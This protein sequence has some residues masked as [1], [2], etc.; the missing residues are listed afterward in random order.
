MNVYQCRGLLG[1]AFCITAVLDGTVAADEAARLRVL[2]YNIHHGA[3]VDGKLDLERIAA[4]IRSASPDVVALQEVDQGTMRTNG[5]KQAEELSRLTDMQA[6]FGKN[7]DYE[8][9]DYGNAVLTKLPMQSHENVALP[10]FDDDGEQR[11]LLIVELGTPSGEPIVFVSTHLDHRPPDDERMMSA[12]IINNRLSREERPI[13]L[14]GDLNATG[15]SRVLARLSEKWQNASDEET[16]T[17][18]VGKP[19]RQ[20]DYVLF[21]PANRWR[22]VEVSVL[23]ERVASDHRPLLAVLELLPER[24]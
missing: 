11:G 15:D 24:P 5:V 6:V 10:T 22:V 18:P 9:G 7:I 12:H 17:V 3:G 21:R 14:A 4:V 23:D 16:A 20:I 19:R 2:T 1:L 13:I 8:G